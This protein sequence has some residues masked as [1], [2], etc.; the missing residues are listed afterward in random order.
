[1]TQ[2]EKQKLESNIWKYGVYLTTNH[3]LYW[4]LITIYFLTFPNATTQ[5]IGWFLALGQIGGLVLEIPSGYIADKIGHKQ[6]LI[7]AKLCLIIATLLFLIGGH[8]LVF[9][10]GSFFFSAG[11]AFNSGTITA[12]MHETLR[13]LKKDDQFSKIVGKVKS[14]AFAAS[15]VVLAVLPLLTPINIRLPFAAGLVIDIIGLLTVLSFATPARTKVEIEEI[16]TTNFRQVLREG[17]R[18]RFFP[19]AVFT[20]LFTTLIIAGGTYR[21]V[22]EQSLG[23]SV[24]MFGALSSLSRLV[25]SVMS[26]YIYRLKNVLRIELYFFL[27]ALFVVTLIAAAGYVENRWVVVAV[28]ITLSG[29]WLSSISLSEHYKLDYLQGSAFKATLLSFHGLLESLFLIGANL[30]I[31]MLVG[32]VSYRLGLVY[33]AIVGLVALGIAYVVF[34]VKSS[35]HGRRAPQTAR[36]RTKQAQ[37]LP[38]QLE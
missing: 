35:G 32:W 28:F 31:G 26:R 38:T 6:A 14:R 17:S 16:S 22:Y 11:L 2:T 21:E 4:P 34:F 1:M 12:F 5:Q 24:T 10:A 27:V 25:G 30:V 20:A 13:A 29:F 37:T 23:I 9:A 8:Y 33:F 19:V 36:V 3:R 15:A 18:R 7:I